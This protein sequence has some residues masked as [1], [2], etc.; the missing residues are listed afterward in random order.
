MSNYQLNRS[1]ERVEDYNPSKCTKF[2]NCLNCKISL[3]LTKVENQADF[4]SQVTFLEESVVHIIVPLF[5]LKR[6]NNPSLVNYHKSTENCGESFVTIQT[7]SELVELIILI[8]WLG[9]AIIRQLHSTSNSE[10]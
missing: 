2:E 1:V 6:L 7:L 3:T 4:N 8:S 9:K 5:Q 10:Y